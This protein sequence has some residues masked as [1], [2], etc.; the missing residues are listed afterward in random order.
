MEV[1][2]DF[3]KYGSLIKF[4]ILGKN[5]SRRHFEIFLFFPQKIEFDISCNLSPFETICM[6]C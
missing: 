2:V 1:M 6:K 4:S 3:I 5:Y